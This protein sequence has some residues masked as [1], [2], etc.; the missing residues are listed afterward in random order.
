MSYQ[1]IVDGVRAVHRANVKQFRADPNGDLPACK[2]R[3]G[4]RTCE[5]CGRDVSRHRRAC[6]AIPSS[7]RWRVEYPAP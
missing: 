7:M 3:L 1:E 6:S 5:R 4:T 2:P